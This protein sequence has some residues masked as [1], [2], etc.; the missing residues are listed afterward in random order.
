MKI[1]FATS[2]NPKYSTVSDKIFKRFQAVKDFQIDKWV[3]RS[4]GASQFDRTVEEIK[5]CDAF[6][7]VI[8]EKS[9]WPTVELAILN[10]LR[11]LKKKKMKDR[12]FIF[13]AHSVPSSQLYREFSPDVFPFDENN[14][15]AL[16]SQVDRCIEHWLDDQDPYCILDGHKHV[17]VI[18]D[19]SA[20]VTNIQKIRVRQGNN[21][22][23]SVIPSRFSITDDVPKRAGRAL[24]PIPR[25]LAKGS[26]D[27]RVPS[28]A[29]RILSPAPDNVDIATIEDLG[30][31]GE[32]NQ[33]SFNVVLTRQLGPKEMLEWTWGYTFPKMYRTKGK[34]ESGF[35]ARYRA[36]KYTFK[37]AFALPM[38]GDGKIKFKESP[39]LFHLDGKGKERRAPIAVP[40]QL[41]LYFMEFV[42][43]NL[44]AINKDDRLVVRWNRKS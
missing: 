34:D 8:V 14:L 38:A 37:I 42:W 27:P 39:V 31:K 6:V 9:L 30:P 25:M 13:R 18:A 20:T 21:A 29:C 32:A 15:P 4:P 19:G 28:F 36:E 41:S 1:F 7:A 10:T 12:V 17:Y 3:A 23:L 44:K 43:R 5:S 2:F 35:I 40:P 11:G 16:M 22:R 26:V 24:P 33:R